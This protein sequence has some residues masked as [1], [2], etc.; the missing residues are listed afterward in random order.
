MQPMDILFI[1]IEI[2]PLWKIM[3]RL[4]DISRRADTT[5]S[6]P[7]SVV[8]SEQAAGFQFLNHRRHSYFIY[9]YSFIFYKIK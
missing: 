3:E 8:S 2:W 9:R 7:D 5:Q 4:K 1:D 6:G